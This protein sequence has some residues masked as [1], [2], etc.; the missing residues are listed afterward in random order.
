MVTDVVDLRALY[1]SMLIDFIYSSLSSGGTV[2]INYIIN[3]YLYKLKN[4]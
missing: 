4:Q 2:I 3:I 1:G